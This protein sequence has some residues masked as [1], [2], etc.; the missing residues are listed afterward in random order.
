MGVW[1]AVMIEREDP[2]GRVLQ[3][4][5][6]TGAL[7][8]RSDVG[9]PWGV[10]VPKTPTA[11]FHVVERGRATLSIGGTTTT[12]HEGDLAL[13]PRGVDHRVGSSADVAGVPLTR[14]LAL[15]GSR[16]W[17]LTIG[18]EPRTRILCG[19]IEIGAG[20]HHPLVATLP[21]MILVPR[22]THGSLGAVIRALSEESISALPGAYAIITRLCEA[23][24][25]IAARHWLQSEP[26]SEGWLAALNDPMTSRALV[27]MHGDLAR[28]WTMTELARRVGLSRPALAKR[29]VTQLGVPPLR[30][31]ARIRLMTATQLLEIPGVPLVE[32]AERVGYGSAEAFSR[33]FKRQHGRSPSTFRMQQD[34]RA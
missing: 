9:G 5:R 18:P 2:L 4:L 21:P 1:C 32:I 33:A 16:G 27:A 25:C 3:A 14:V 6:L 20:V 31:L 26:L 12:L 15:A 17:H 22:A 28:A 7:Y 29:F 10:A 34:H 13:V 23:V 19:H 8:F 24:F 30:Y 11:T